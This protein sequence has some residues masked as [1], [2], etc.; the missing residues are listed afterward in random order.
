MLR[1]LL[2]LL[3]IASTASAQIVPAPQNVELDSAHSITGDSIRCE[4]L[5]FK[6]QVD[7]FVAALEKLGAKNV[8]ITTD[9][10]LNPVVV[11]ARDSSL[12][13]AGYSINSNDNQ[14]TINAAS[15][16][17]AAH[18]AASLLQ[19]VTLENGEITWPSMTIDDHPDCSYRS[20][21]VD[22]GRNPHS[23]ATLRRIVDMMWFYKVNYLQLHLTD[24]QLFSWP[25]KAFP[26]LYRS[27]AGW[28]WDD[29]VALESYS[30]ARGVTIIPELEAP[31]HSGILRREYPEIFG[32]T[33]TDLATKPK[34]QRGLETLLAELLSVFKATPFIHIGGDEASGVPMND[35]RD[36]IN[37]LNTFLNAKGKRTLVW[38]GPHLGEGKHKV[39]E[40]VVH[41]NWRTVDF[42]AQQMLDAGYEIVNAAWNPLYVV[43]HYPRTMFTA[44]DV[45]RCYNWD[46]QSFGHID[47]RF[48]TYENPH[49]T[50]T[51][52]GILGFCMPWW[53][54][55]EENVIPLCLPRLAAVASAAWNREGERNFADYKNRQKQTLPILE[56]IADYKL[57]ETPFADPESQKDNVAYRAKVTP[58]DGASQPHFGPQRLTNGFP[59]RFDHFLGFPTQPKPLEIL[60][61]LKSPSAVGRIVIYERAIGTSHE[62]YELHVSPDGKTFAKIGSAQ[63]GSRGEKNHVVHS[64][65]VREIRFIKIV[66]QGCHGLTFPSFSRLSEVMAFAE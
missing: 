49:R 48:S 22:M 50:K 63:K 39:A 51:A 13:P 26:K 64:F 52:E 54:G 19:T 8:T 66:T 11:F 60:I 45:E 23:P 40:N 62:I 32:N 24:D 14:L 21:M 6:D 35:Q 61:E 9:P 56:K 46:I 41:M 7:A 57:P 47:H 25:S 38:E 42:P 15:S 43:D 53:E 37:R 44:V 33:S 16:Q 36:L 31:G 65:P 30:Q 28:E 59:D 5:E 10:A 18:A 34:A 3:F 20:F 1:S 55:R 17:G 2:L 29:F 4:T 58:S 12:P 27:R